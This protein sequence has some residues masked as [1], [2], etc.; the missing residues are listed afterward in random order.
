M[1]EIR[2]M[3]SLSWCV[4]GAYRI[5]LTIH[6][7]V[8]FTTICNFLPTFFCGEQPLIT[9][10]KRTRTAAHFVRNFFSQSVAMHLAFTWWHFDCQRLANIHRSDF[11]KIRELNS[12]Y[13]R[14]TETRDL[15]CSE[16]NTVEWS[17]FFS[18]IQNKSAKLTG[19]YWAFALSSHAM[20][21][22]AIIS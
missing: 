8:I 9:N 11:S 17:H 16:S 21:A 22:N 19:Y 6:W 4:R 10:W 5:S 20:D 14:T 12:R 13:I 1:E 7:E 15:Q 18:E 2:M 3:P